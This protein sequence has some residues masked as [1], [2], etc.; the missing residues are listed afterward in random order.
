MYEVY[1]TELAQEDL[2]EACVYLKFRT[3]GL[4][5]ACRL[6][7]G[8]EDKIGLLEKTPKAFPLVADQ[9]LS[10]LG[11]RWV[12]VSGAYHLFYIIDER[13]GRVNIER[14][15]HSSRSWEALLA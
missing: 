12:R 8:Y 11:Y 14:M 3:G 7:D 15:L 5:A 4:Q 6:L 2:R 10:S 9:M 1:E 13:S